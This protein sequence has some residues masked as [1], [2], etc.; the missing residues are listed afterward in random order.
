MIGTDRIQVIQGDTAYLNGVIS[1]RKLAF[2]TDLQSLVYSP[3]GYIWIPCKM[4]GSGTEII[5]DGQGKIPLSYLPDYI[6][7]THYVHIQSSVSSVWV[8]ANPFKRP[9]SISFIDSSGN[10]FWCGFVYNGD[11]SIITATL[12][13]PMSGKAVLL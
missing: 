7:V 1:S 5:L 8:I 6:T 13:D 12:S 9:V 2:N 11:Y 3:D 4:D 10:P